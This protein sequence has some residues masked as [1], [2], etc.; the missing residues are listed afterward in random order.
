MADSRTVMTA[1]SE[2][3]S[4]RALPFCTSSITTNQRAPE[5]AKTLIQGI[6]SFTRPAACELVDQRFYGDGRFL[7]RVGF[8]VVSWVAKRGCSLES[9]EAVPDLD[10]LAVA[11]IGRSMTGWGRDSLRGMSQ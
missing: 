10:S 2:C 6:K 9:A 8:L 1:A 7:R 3:H 4:Q 5:A 11:G